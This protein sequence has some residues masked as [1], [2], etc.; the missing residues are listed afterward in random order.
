[1]YDTHALHPENWSLKEK[2]LR[3]DHGWTEPV[4]GA[5]AVW[6]ADREGTAG[7]SAWAG[8]SPEVWHSQA[9]AGGSV[10]AQCLG[11]QTLIAEAI[12]AFCGGWGGLNLVSSLP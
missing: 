2:L 6:S 1:M 7:K 3:S 9:V 8:L 12:Y 5:P 4:R 11:I 10:S